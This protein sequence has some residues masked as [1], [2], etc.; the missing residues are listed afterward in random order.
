MYVT[1]RNSGKPHVWPKRQRMNI[2]PSGSKPISV[3]LKH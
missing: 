2:V 3:I 1:K